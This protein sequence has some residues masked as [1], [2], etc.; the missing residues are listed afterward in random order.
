MALSRRYALSGVRVRLV[1]IAG[2]SRPPNRENTFEWVGHC[3]VSPVARADS[4]AWLGGLWPRG[5]SSIAW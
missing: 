5:Q 3:P 4:A 1:V 2:R